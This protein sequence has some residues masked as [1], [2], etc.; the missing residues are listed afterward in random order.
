VDKHRGVKGFVDG[1]L[2]SHTAAFLEP[3]T[4]LQT[5]TGLFVNSEEDLYNWIW[6]PTGPGCRL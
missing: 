2:G 1:S 4:D 5:D 6:N 3:Y